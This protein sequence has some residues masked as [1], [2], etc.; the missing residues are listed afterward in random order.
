MSE[1]AFKAVPAIVPEAWANEAEVREAFEEALRCGER[2]IIF[3]VAA[4]GSETVQGTAHYTRTTTRVRFTEM[5][6]LLIAKMYSWLT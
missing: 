1:P 5:C 6:A 2:I 3:W 4:D